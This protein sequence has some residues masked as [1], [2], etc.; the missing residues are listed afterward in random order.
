MKKTTFFLAILL[1]FTQRSS[2]AI[3]EQMAGLYSLAVGTVFGITSLVSVYDNAIH[4]TIQD[5]LFITSLSTAFGVVTGGIAYLLFREM[6]PK[7]WLERAV[8]IIERLKK[9]PLAIQLFNE[10]ELLK[11]LKN[12]CYD[13]DLWV[14]SASLKL[15]IKITD[16]R[17]AISLLKAVIDSDDQ[18]YKSKALKA[19][20]TADDMFENL[21]Q[22]LIM[23]KE[24]KEYL[25]QYE[26]KQQQLI[27][28][29]KIELQ[30]EQIHAM[31]HNKRHSKF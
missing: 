8:E 28:Q 17:H 24:S 27:A 4:T 23:V 6:T 19:I 14:I 21:K 20:K 31:Y 22:A 16:I 25:K 10:S 13:S 26:L 7:R 12:E 29:Q 30:K 15:Q 1:L 11:I 2:L 9:Y 3:T 5:K 18:L